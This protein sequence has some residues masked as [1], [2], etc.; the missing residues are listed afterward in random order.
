MKRVDIGRMFRTVI[1]TGLYSIK[2]TCSVLLT[3]VITQ[4]EEP[5]LTHPVFRAP[6]RETAVRGDGDGDGGRQS[7]TMERKSVAS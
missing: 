3:K 7:H 4:G 5:Q 1:H 2:T 6:S